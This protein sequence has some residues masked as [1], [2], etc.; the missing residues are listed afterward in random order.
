MAREETPDIILLDIM[1]ETTTDGFEFCREARRDPCI[2]H[3]PILGISTIEKVIGVHY[4]SDFDPALFPVDG[5][6]SKPVT[7]ENL[8]AELK[9][10]IP[11]EV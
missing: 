5:Y 7:P 10:L 6:L 1:M 9:R 3:M 8:F 4:P 2:K 11:A